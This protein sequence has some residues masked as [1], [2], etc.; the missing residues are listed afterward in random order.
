MIS[1]L[2]VRL[3]GDD[4]LAAFLVALPAMIYVLV[5]NH[6]RMTW[7]CPRCGRRFHMKWVLFYSDAWSR[8]CAHCG[9]PLWAPPPYEDEAAT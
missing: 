1:W 2:L 4:G 6:G 8:R 9:L 3:G 7:P 5:A